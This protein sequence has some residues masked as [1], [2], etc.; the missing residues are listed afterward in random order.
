MEAGE[1]RSNRFFSADLHLVPR[2]AVRHCRRVDAGAGAGG[3][4][5]RAH[6]VVGLGGIRIVFSSTAPSVQTPVQSG[7]SSYPI[8][9]IPDARNFTT[10]YK[11][12][13]RLCSDKDTAVSLCRQGTPHWASEE[14]K[15]SYGNI[16]RPCVVGGDNA[17]TWH[18]GPTIWTPVP[19]TS[20][21]PWGQGECTSVCRSGRRWPVLLGDVNGEISGSESPGWHLR[22]G[23]DNRQWR[24][25]YA[26]HPLRSGESP[27]GLRVS[28]SRV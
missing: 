16:H 19:T 8:L 13:L 14:V 22:G 17:R 2:S 25:Y 23:R 27:L 15:R 11:G 9:C 18:R 4:R 24:R 21:P 3:R 6:H 1:G 7:G 5:T 12:R 28:E 20:P 10:L 26:S